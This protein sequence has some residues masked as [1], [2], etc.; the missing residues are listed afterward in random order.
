MA[1][2]CDRH[3]STGTQPTLFVLL[4]E[5]NNCFQTRHQYRAASKFSHNTVDFTETTVICTGIFAAVIND[6]KI[7]CTYSTETGFAEYRRHLIL[8]ISQDGAFTDSIENL[9]VNSF[10]LKA[11]TDHLEGGSRLVYSFD[12]YW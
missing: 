5:H 10:I 7:L 12:P 3:L 6:G 2:S 1:S 4:F 11:L 9:S 8:E